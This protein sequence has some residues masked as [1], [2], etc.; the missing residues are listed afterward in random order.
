MYHKFLVQ[1]KWA[2]AFYERPP[3][4]AAIKPIDPL[5][6]RGGPVIRVWV[7]DTGVFK[8]I[9]TCNDAF[10]ETC[11]GLSGHPLTEDAEQ[12]LHDVPFVHSDALDYTHN[13]FVLREN[14][15]LGPVLF[16]GNGDRDLSSVLPAAARFSNHMNVT[17]VDGRQRLVSVCNPG[18]CQKCAFVVGGV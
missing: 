4:F 17:F 8:D 13:N 12:D 15:D 5:Y 10:C 16:T 7:G 3:V 9:M 6:E 14:N 11:A 2:G 1:N 18:H